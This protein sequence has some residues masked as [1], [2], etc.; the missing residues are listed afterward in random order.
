ME[1]YSG[2]GPHA[3]ADIDAAEAARARLIARLRLPSWFHLSL[4]AAV[5]A[6]IAGLAPWVVTESRTGLIGAAAGCAIF[7]AIAGL[8]LTRFRLVNRV[9]IDGLF[10]RVVMGTSTNASLSY[11]AGLGAAI[12][13]AAQEQWWIMGLAAIG[14]G[15]GYGVSGR[16]WWR[17]YLRNPDAHARGESRPTI[18]VVGAI[19]AVGLLV[20]VAQA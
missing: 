6:Q 20:L 3:A 15:V 18:L 5:A 8:Q 17:S 7:L 16:A 12:W 14:G 10:S 19:A 9:R 1:S 4:G 2:S 11:A 13:A